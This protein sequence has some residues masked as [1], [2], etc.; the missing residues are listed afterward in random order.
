MMCM[1]LGNMDALYKNLKPFSALLL[2]EDPSRNK[3]CI[4]KKTYHCSTCMFDI[5][6]L[7]LFFQLIFTDTA[8][9][10][11]PESAIKCIA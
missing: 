2:K 1:L 3:T 5:P 10:G 6:A 11:F 8:R 9:H 4:E 7:I